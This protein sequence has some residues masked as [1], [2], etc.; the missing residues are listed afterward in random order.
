MTTISVALSAMPLTFAAEALTTVV[1]IMAQARRR[2]HSFLELVF[3]VV[4][5]FFVIFF[6]GSAPWPVYYHQEGYLSIEHFP[7]MRV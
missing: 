7:S 3:I 4:P 6:L 5:L 1:T 2:L